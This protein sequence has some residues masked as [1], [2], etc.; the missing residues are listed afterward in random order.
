MHGLASVH[1]R[2]KRLEALQQ[3]RYEEDLDGLLSQ[4]SDR[5]FA[6]FYALVLCRR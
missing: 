6:G 2:L 5:E 1:G 3:A 4:L